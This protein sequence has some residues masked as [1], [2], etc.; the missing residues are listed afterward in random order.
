MKEI[1]FKIFRL[2]RDQKTI[3]RIEEEGRKYNLPESV[4]ITGPD[5]FTFIEDIIKNCKEDYALLCHD[6]VFVPLDIEQ[7]V[8]ECIQK[9]NA[10]CGS[11]NWG[12]VGNSGIEAISFRTVRFLRD[13][14]TAIVPY[15][16]Q[17]IPVVSVDGNV[18][19]LHIKN[20]RRNKVEL[21]DNLQ[22]F[23]LY[24]FITL[25]ECY[26]KN[27][28]AFVDST[29]YVYHKSGG[30]QKGF[31]KFCGGDK[32]QQYWS[33]RF[34]N[35]KI[36]TI[37]GL[38]KIKSPN[39]DYLKEDD[40][41][42]KVDFY[43]IVEKRILSI[44]KDREKP[45][46]NI[47]T[48]TQFRNVNTLRRLIESVQLSQRVNQLHLDLRLIVSFNNGKVADSEDTIDNLKRS[49]KELEIKFIKNGLSPTLAPRLQAI[50]DAVKEIPIDKNQFVWVVDDD[51]F[52]FPK[53]LNLLSHYLNNEIIFIGKS[54][55]FDE[56]WSFD[57][58]F[59]NKSSAKP[60]YYSEAYARNYFGK[61]HVP[62]C[63]VIYPVKVL[64][65]L[66]VKYK[67]AGDYYEDYALLFLAQANHNIQYLPILIAGISHQDKNTVLEN[68][69][70]HW[71]Y[72]YATFLTEITNSGVVNNS[73][74]ELIT[75]L[76]KQ[77]M[78]EIA[79][80]A[81]QL[82]G[83]LKSTLKKAIRLYRREGLAGIRRAFRIVAELLGK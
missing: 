38:I 10:Y 75:M 72:S 70:T 51:D 28:L 26:R 33:M 80:F 54:A 64:H 46:I 71:D 34:I 11:E 47:I 76:S 29:L 3:D 36:I 35:H 44:D 41:D 24:D 60:G 4:L 82:G 32:F 18:M 1:Q 8:K 53:E 74:F 9:M 83:G 57:R 78:A 40:K 7:R 30:A 69:R 27:L 77:S 12:V 17:P 16:S 73:V 37:N 23:H 55:S 49:F 25:V 20:M 66:F 39:L 21:P 48:R 59:P 22:G 62:I 19:L 31:D 65:D 15:K 79:M 2:C 68:D 42:Q 67:L 56:T 61:N 5:Y 45:V 43:S 6:D 14:H 58:P 63:S 50:K 13:P 52:I 81:I